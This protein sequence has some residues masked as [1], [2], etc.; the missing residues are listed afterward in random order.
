[1][2]KKQVGEERVRSA[3]TSTLLFITKGTQDTPHGGISS[4]EAPFSVITAA[5][6]RLTH[7]TSQYRHSVLSGISIKLLPSR[8]REPC[9]RGG[10]RRARAGR[11]RGHQEN[12]FF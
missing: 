11:E 2:T 8:L 12:K 7:K 4:R 6:V 3:S 10:R 5:C 1:M 9:G